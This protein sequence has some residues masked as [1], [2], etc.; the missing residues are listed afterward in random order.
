MEVGVVVDPDVEIAA[1]VF[2]FSPLIA[3]PI[4][5]CGVIAP[6]RLTLIVHLGRVV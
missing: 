6:F 2:F 3:L 4:Y 1:A 5:L